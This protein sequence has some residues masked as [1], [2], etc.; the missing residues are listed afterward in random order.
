MI[1]LPLTSNFADGDVCVS[2]THVYI[3]DTNNH[4]IV[5]RL[6]SDF[7]FVSSFGT[8][9]SGDDEFDTPIGICTDDTHLY[10]V[11]SGNDRI[12]KHL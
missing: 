11:D 3:C 1:T 6:K 12:K 5:K 4:R 8:Q 9:G 7:S 2:S 10:I